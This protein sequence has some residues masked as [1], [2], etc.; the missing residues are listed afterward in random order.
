MPDTPDPTFTP[1][2]V[3]DLWFPETG[4]DETPQTFAAFWH[5]RMQGG[6]DARIISD[7]ADLT[8]AAAEGRLTHWAETPR[9]RLALLIVLDQ[10]PRSLW[11]DTP[12]AYAQDIQATRLAL[13]GIACGHIDAL[14]PWEMSFFV[15]AISHCEG[16]DHLERMQALDPLVERIDAL[17]PAHLRDETRSLMRQHERV[18][19]IIA[20][21]GRH[22]HRN[23][24]LSRRT[25]AEEAEYIATGDFPHLPSKD[26]D[27][28]KA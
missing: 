25:T 18:K 16:P 28:V 21:F 23:A 1:E 9:G 26:A 3:L 12:A 7:F 24:I 22:P 4:F 8:V 6:M 5:E 17:L 2:T 19:G 15:I 20:K 14:A 27:T 11:R 13:D 10:F